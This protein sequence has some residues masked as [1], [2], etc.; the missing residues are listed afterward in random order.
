MIPPASFFALRV[1]VDQQL[2]IFPFSLIERTIPAHPPS[3]AVFSIRPVVPRL[4]IVPSVYGN[5]AVPFSESSVIDTLIVCPCP[6]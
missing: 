6:S 5:I 2:I 4:I 3:V 1:T